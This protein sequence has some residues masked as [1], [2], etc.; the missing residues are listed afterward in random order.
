MLGIVRTAAS[1]GLLSNFVFGYH[2][3]GE[4]GTL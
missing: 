3:Q 2:D 1:N 4:I